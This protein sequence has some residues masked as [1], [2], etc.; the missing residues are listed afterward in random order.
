MADTR[1]AQATK[2]T[3]DRRGLTRAEFAQ[4]AG[5]SERCLYEVLGGGPVTGATLARLQRAGV[6]VADRRVIASLDSAA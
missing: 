2:K 3:I 4:L 6:V 5:L 1:L